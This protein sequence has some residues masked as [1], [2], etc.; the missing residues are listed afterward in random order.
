MAYVRIG[1]FSL[2]GHFL[3]KT[4]KAKW[5]CVSS[6][7]RSTTTLSNSRKLGIERGANGEKS[8]LR[9]K[10]RNQTRKRNRPPLPYLSPFFYVHFTV[11]HIPL[12]LYIPLPCSTSCPVTHVRRA[13]YDTYSLPPNTSFVFVLLHIRISEGEITVKLSLGWCWVG[14][15]PAEFTQPE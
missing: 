12:C 14:T 15:A 7:A 1:R 10:E 4:K 5:W 2:V 13:L 8:S 6:K 3:T 9:E 11:P